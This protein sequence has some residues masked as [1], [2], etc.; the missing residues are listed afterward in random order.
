MDLF[1]ASQRILSDLIIFAFFKVLEEA[2]SKNKTSRQP[3]FDN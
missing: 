2:Q 1:S 3:A